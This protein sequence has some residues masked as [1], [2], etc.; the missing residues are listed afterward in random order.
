MINHLT[1]IAAIETV[2][3][4][5][6][7]KQ[8]LFVYQIARL[9]YRIYKSLL[10]W[11]EVNALIVE[12]EQNIK[13]LNAS[14]LA[15][16]E[17]KVAEKL[18]TW[19]TKSEYRLFKLNLRKNKIDIAKIIINQSKLEQTKQA[20]IAL[21]KDITEIDIQKQRFSVVISE[22]RIEIPENSA[23]ESSEKFRQGN[24]ENPINVSIRTFLK[25]YLLMAS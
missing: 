15:A 23:F 21:E 17:G 25:E 3:M 18:L 14:I 5:L 13:S 4:R 12:E 1:S 19:K 11:N 20:L 9:E 8:K 2:L 6:S 22:N 16:G 7:I 24:E 10:K